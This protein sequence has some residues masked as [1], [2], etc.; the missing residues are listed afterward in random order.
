MNNKMAYFN[1][2]SMFCGI[3]ISMLFSLTGSSFWIAGI[4]GTIIGCLLLSFVKSVNDNK[5]IK[6]I[7]GFILA[8]VSLIILVNMGHSLYLKE[9]PLSILTIGALL[10]IYY[11][12][13]SKKGP[14]KKTVYIF[15][16]YSIILF[17]LKIIGLYSH[18]SIENMLPIYPIDV[19]VC[20]F[21]CCANYVFK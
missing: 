5:I 10:P 14:L 9:T 13:R 2:R 4:L 19:N 12:S 3:G 21:R 7:G 16:I 15:F 11:I 18:I 8:T 20:D 17:F 1:G 6:T